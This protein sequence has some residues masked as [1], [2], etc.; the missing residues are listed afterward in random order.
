LNVFPV[1][2]PGR[3]AWAYL[4]AAVLVVAGVALILDRKAWMAATYLGTM[5]LLL[6]LFVYLPILVASPTDLESLNYFFDTLAF[7]GAIL[8]LADALGERPAVG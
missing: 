4:A 6:M 5:I 3:L 2:I 8:V 7:G 1:R